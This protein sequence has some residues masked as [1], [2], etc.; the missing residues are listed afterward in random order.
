MLNAS[1]GAAALAFAGRG[2]L[3]VGVRDPQVKRDRQTGEGEPDWTAATVLA[4]LCCLHAPL[5]LPYRFS[6]SGSW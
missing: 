2:A 5:I 4:E 6:R 1:N 3:W